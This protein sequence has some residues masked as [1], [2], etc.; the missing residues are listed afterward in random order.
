MSERY[1]D[2][3]ANGQLPSELELPFF[4][5]ERP[6]RPRVTVRLDR[7]VPPGAVGGLAAREDVDSNCACE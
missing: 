3:Q 2:Q 6:V 4:D 1:P 5:P 7:T